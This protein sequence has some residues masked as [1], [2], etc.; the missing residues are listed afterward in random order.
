MAGEH[1]KFLPCH[2]QPIQGEE[3]AEGTS[4]NLFLDL[5]WHSRALF[6]MTRSYAGDSDPA[7]DRVVLN[8]VECFSDRLRSW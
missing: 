1:F 3:G 8:D 4:F 5:R 7:C 2:V 6:Q